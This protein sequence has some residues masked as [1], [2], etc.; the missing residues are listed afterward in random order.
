MRLPR[1]LSRTRDRLKAL[2]DYLGVSYV[3]DRWGDPE[4]IDNAYA[5]NKLITR[6]LKRIEKKVFTAKE[7]DA[8]RHDHDD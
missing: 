4:H 8:F 3:V 1:F 5:Q 2:E 7:R 6:R